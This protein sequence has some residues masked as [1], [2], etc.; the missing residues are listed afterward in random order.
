MAENGE[1][2]IVEV[3]GSVT[4]KKFNNQDGIIELRSLNPK[5]KPI[6]KFE[7][8]RIIGKVII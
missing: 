5:Y 2:V 3:D 7:T 1:I 6:T 4:C 8:I